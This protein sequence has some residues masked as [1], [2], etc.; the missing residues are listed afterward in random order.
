MPTIIKHRRG[1]IVP[2]FLGE[3]G[4]HSVVLFTIAIAIAISMAIPVAISI[5]IAI[6][7]AKWLLVLAAGISFL[8]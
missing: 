8:G 5:A 6:D 3:Q 2:L 1:L 7:F 4:R